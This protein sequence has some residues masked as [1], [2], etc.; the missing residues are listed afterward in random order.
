MTARPTRRA[1]L[2]ALAGVSLLP[3]AGCSVE[4]PTDPFAPKRCPNKPSPITADVLRSWLPAYE[5]DYSWNATL[6]D[7]RWNRRSLQNFAITGLT[8]TVPEPTIEMLDDGYLAWFDT[9]TRHLT[10]E[11]GQYGMGSGSLHADVGVA[12]FVSPTQFL[13][14]PSME[15][16]DPR[17]SEVGS[18][19][20]CW[21]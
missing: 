15:K 18:P 20:R 12:Y 10:Y 3:L 17:E 11:H 5:H 6:R 9:V 7:V 16:V 14:A 2:G 21:L 4:A 13:R 19:P 1:L 8:V